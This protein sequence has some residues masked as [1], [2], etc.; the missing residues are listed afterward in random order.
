MNW[1]KIF[2]GKNV[3]LFA[4]SMFPIL[5]FVYPVKFCISIVLFLLERS[6]V[7]KLKAVLMQTFGRQRKFFFFFMGNVVVNLK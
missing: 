2:Y 3:F 7:R 6:V 1:L 4:T 5:H